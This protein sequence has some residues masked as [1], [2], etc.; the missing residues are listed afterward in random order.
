MREFLLGVVVAMTV[1]AAAFF[2]RFWRQSHDRFFAL[3]AL[4]FTVMAAN[5]AGQLVIF[6]EHEG[7]TLLYGV[8]L[9]SFV[10]ILVAIWD[11]NRGRE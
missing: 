9:L 1:S 11:K 7:N 10:L 3:L 2:W 8:R 6:E 5:R 4:A